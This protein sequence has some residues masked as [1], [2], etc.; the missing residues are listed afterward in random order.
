MLET[1]GNDTSF[2]FLALLTLAWGRSRAAGVMYE[3][4][5]DTVLFAD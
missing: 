2:P 1:R 4:L 3:A 5:R